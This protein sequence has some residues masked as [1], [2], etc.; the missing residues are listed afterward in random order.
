MHTLLQLVKNSTAGGARA[1]H[2]QEVQLEAQVNYNLS[3][4]NSI[5]GVI[6][7]VNPLNTASRDLRVLETAR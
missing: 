7:L 2:F 3:N 4:I 6:K 1:F 5:Y